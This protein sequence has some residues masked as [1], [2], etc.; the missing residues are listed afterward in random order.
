MDKMSEHF[1]TA[2]EAWSM[3]QKTEGDEGAE[4]AERFERYFYEL[5]NELKVWYNT[6]EVKP[7]TVE[8]V[9]ELPT[10]K[11]FAEQIPGPVYITFLTELEDIVEGFET[12][13]FD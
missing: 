1:D 9:E 12:S 10:I 11:R 6:L 7:E 2:L 13:R 8:E 5:M 3:M 4:W